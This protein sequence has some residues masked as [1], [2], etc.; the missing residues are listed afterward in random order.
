M[1]KMNMERIRRAKNFFKFRNKIAPGQ[2]E[3][4]LMERRQELLRQRSN[5]ILERA[6]REAQTMRLTEFSR[7]ARTKHLV[8]KFLNSKIRELEERGLPTEK[9]KERLKHV[10]EIT[11]NLMRLPQVRN[12]IGIQ[13]SQL[14]D[15]EKT[16]KQEARKAREF[17][18]KVATLGL[19]ASPVTAGASLSL[20]AGIILADEGE[21]AAKKITELGEVQRAS[22]ERTGNP[23]YRLKEINK[24]LR[25]IGKN[26]RAIEAR[27][28][29]E[30]AEG[31]AQK[32]VRKGT[33]SEQ[34]AY[35]RA[36]RR[37]GRN[38]KS[39]QEALIH[40]GMPERAREI[41]YARKAEDYYKIR[42]IKPTDEQL[43]SF[44]L[45]MKKQEKKYLH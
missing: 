40:G 38:P 2:K 35:E 23:K 28:E 3:I 30:Q 4:K 43:G 9:L 44:I 37:L 42:G 32:S 17:D 26:R 21:I 6:V 36:V 19:F 14:Y 27:N 45:Q 25:R 34:E 31:E 13:K 15:R 29:K 41:I 10:D 12:E 18:K 24:E 16:A 33:R 11:S 5:L 7:R 20:A 1:F 22:E 39:L 8:R